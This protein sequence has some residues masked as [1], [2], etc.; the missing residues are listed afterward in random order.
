M[1]AFCLF[2]KERMGLQALGTKYSVYKFMK[3]SESLLAENGQ[4]LSAHFLVGL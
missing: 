2:Y 3:Y 4:L 1:T